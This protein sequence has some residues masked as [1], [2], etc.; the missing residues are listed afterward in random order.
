MCQEAQKRLV[1]DYSYSI[2]QPILS[3]YFQTD[4]LNDFTA[5]SRLNSNL[6]LLCLKQKVLK[7]T[8]Y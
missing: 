1:R 6:L 3:L 8:T 5:P 2:R 4:F 7:L